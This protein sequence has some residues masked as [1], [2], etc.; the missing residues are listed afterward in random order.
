MS[1]LTRLSRPLRMVG[2]S[3]SAA[4]PS[5]YAS[6]SASVIAAGRLSTVARH[7]SSSSVSMDQSSKMG[8]PSEDLVLFE[9]HQSTRLYK[10]NRPAKLNSLNQEMIDLLSSKIKNWRELESCKVIIGTGDSRAFCAGGDVKQL[11]LDLKEGKETALPFFKSEFQLNWTLG[12]LGKPY[13]AVID[14]VTMGG[15]AGLSLPAAI[16]VATPRTIFA[17]PETKIGYAPDVGANYYLAQLDGAI[18]AWLAI[19]GQELYGRAAYELG[20]AT[21]Y[22]TPNVLPEII[23]QITQLESPTLA[24]ISSLVSSYSSAPSSS[25]EPS[26]KASPDGPSPIKGEIREFLDKTFSLKSIAE[27]DQALSKAATNEKLSQEVRDWAK[28]QKE[29]IDQRGPTST[30]VALAGYKKAKESRRLDRTLLNDF[31]MATA[32]SGP[33]RS[34]EDFVKGVSAVLIDRSKTPTD[35]IPSSRS[36]P[37]LSPKEIE[38]NFFTPSK[39]QTSGDLQLEFEPI[40]ASKLDSGKDSTWGRFRKYGLPS[41]ANIRASVDGYAPGSG[42]FALTE[43]ELIDSFVDASGEVAGTRRDEIEARVKDVVSRHCKKDKDGYL[44]W[45]S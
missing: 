18:G 13:I 35:W 14:G 20:I 7:L 34:T 12:R 23:S 30:A 9:S 36:D 37:S 33:K 43:K 3:A 17:M 21:H 1:G 41:E 22:V 6:S 25:S 39:N 10:L 28:L 31:S 40:S 16:R 2:A 5:R 19:T 29:L 15:G 8:S 26:S 32:F 45:R 27:V 38:K 24:Q 4:G 42:A 11:V 44:E